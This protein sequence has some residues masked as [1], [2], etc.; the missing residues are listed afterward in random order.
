MLAGC[1]AEEKI[2]EAVIIL[3]DII[4]LSKSEIEVVFEDLNID[5]MFVGVGTPTEENQLLFVDYGQVFSIG[6]EF[7]IDNLLPTIIFL[8]YSDGSIFLQY[9][10]YHM[11]DLI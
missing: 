10:I 1:K 2:D 9:Y 5:I 3:S 11:T 4:G 6:D 8:S 7:E